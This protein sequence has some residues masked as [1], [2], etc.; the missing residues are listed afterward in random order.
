M[1]AV[2]EH[3]IGACPVSGFVDDSIKEIL[4]L[5]EGEIPVYTISIGKRKKL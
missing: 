2:A 4:D 3:N 5:T 1:L